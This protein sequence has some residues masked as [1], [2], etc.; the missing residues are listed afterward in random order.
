MGRVITEGFLEHL[1]EHEIKPKP[2]GFGLLGKPIMIIGGQGV[3]Q[4]INS[5]HNFCLEDNH[6][7]CPV[8]PNLVQL[9]LQLAI[10]W[11]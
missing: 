6:L 1:R 3:S 10:M 5:S 8:P 11:T 7:Q 9:P 2:A 4:H